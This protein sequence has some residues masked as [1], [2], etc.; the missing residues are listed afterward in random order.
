MMKEKIKWIKIAEKKIS[1]ITIGIVLLIGSYLLVLSDGAFA[2]KGTIVN[3][4][5]RI[6]IQSVVQE[7]LQ[8][9]VQK[10]IKTKEES[11]KE[12][13]ELLKRYPNLD[14][15]IKGIL[16]K[17]I[18]TGNIPVIVSCD[19]NLTFGEI[20]ILQKNKA[21]IEVTESRVCKYE[22]GPSEEGIYTHLFTLI[23][24]GKEWE[25]EK[26]EDGTEVKGELLTKDVKKLLPVLSPEE[27]V[28]NQKIEEQRIKKES[29][30][31]MSSSYTYNRNNA[32]WYGSYYAINP[33]SSFR[34]WPDAD[35]T[36][37]ISQ[38]VWYG[39]WPMVGWWPDKY[40]TA[41][42]WY[43]FGW[44][45]TQSYTWTSAHYWWWFTYNR[46]RGYLTSD[47]CSL[48]NG[49]IVQRDREPNGYIDHSTIV[50]YKNGC[51]IR[52]S[53]HTPNTRNRSLW[54][55]MSQ[56]PSANFYGWRLY[57]SGN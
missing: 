22:T 46:P 45:N 14:S 30:S 28:K 43:A 27:A 44:P 17:G 37:F 25:A 38:A 23:K 10:K 36:N 32:A 8:G 47:G 20:E 35:C 5:D 33:N 18:E 3:P 13:K 7:V 56:Y 6:E 54:D 40:S 26:F 42:W 24:K 29:I 12:A 21:K 41:V 53:Y 9:E 50:T 31:T 55:F 4:E 39:N 57:D 52:I 11:V 16:E 49:D 34:Y 15:M 2:K 48:Q 51:D 1:I 19:S